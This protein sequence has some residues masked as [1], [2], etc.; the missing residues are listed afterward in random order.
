M[1][2][3]IN[4]TTLIVFATLTIWAPSQYKGVMYCIWLDPT[5]IQSLQ[6]YAHTPLI[7][8]QCMPIKYHQ[9]TNILETEAISKV[10]SWF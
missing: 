2:V 6:L 8:D 9:T 4:V 7:H 3:L 10:R 1:C 5:H